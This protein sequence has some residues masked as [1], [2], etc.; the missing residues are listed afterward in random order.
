M[1]HH[2]AEE[3]VYISI[4]AMGAEFNSSLTETVTKNKGSNYFCATTDEDL[5]ECLVKDFDFN[6]FPA[7]F[8]INLSV[9]TSDMEV[10]G[11]VPWD[12]ILTLTSNP[13]IRC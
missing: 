7:A 4:V 11:G 6:M 12:T 10:A 9:R 5:H 2:N 1:I 13:N 8:E 3:G